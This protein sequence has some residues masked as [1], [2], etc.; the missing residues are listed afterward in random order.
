MNADDLAG[1]D[2]VVYD[3]DGTLVDLAVDWD[4]VDREAAGLFERHGHDPVDAKLWGLLDRADDLGLREELESLV[5]EYECEGARDSDPLPCAD[6]L[7]LAV[8][9]GVCSLNCEEACRVAL[10]GHDLSD[11]VEAVVGRDSASTYKPD[12]EPLFAALSALGVPPERA[13]FVGDAER[14]ER[15]AERAGVAFVWV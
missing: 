10:E 8:P 11:H 6:A 3:L 15:T 2:A 5:S 4:A 9:T 7:P 1:Y 14:D 12:P 13:V